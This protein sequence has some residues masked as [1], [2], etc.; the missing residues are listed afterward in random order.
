MDEKMERPQLGLGLL[1]ERSKSILRY[2]KKKP[3]K[4]KINPSLLKKSNLQMYY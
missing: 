1:Q 3:S 4:Y 2:S